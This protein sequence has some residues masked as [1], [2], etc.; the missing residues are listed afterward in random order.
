MTD[1]DPHTWPTEAA[2][3]LDDKFAPFPEAEPM[4]MIEMQDQINKTIFALAAMMLPDPE[5][6]LS[7]QEIPAEGV[8]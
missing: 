4:G 7:G 3:Q 8:E 6:P 2:E 5:P 1:T